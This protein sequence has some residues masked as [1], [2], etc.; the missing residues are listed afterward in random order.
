MEFKGIRS[1]KL[2]PKY[3]RRV[4]DIV[5]KSRESDQSPRKT[6]KKYVETHEIA[7]KK[8]ETN[9]KEERRLYPI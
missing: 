1:D 5:Q 3:G 8:S 4:S 7:V 6:N 2:A 9:G